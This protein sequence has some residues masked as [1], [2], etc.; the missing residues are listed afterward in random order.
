MIFHQMPDTQSLE[1]THTIISHLRD[2]KSGLFVHHTQVGVIPH[3]RLH[4]RTASTSTG[5]AMGLVLQTAIP[6]P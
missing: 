2:Y 5:L 1:L 4:L 6:S 3:I